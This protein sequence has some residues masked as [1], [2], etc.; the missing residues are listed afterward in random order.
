[1]KVY[2]S[3]FDIM[4][5]PWATEVDKYV[6]KDIWVRATCRRFKQTFDSYIRVLDKVLEDG[7]IY[8]L[9]NMLPVN[10]TFDNM[11]SLK[12]EMGFTKRFPYLSIHITHPVELA[13]TEDLISSFY[14]DGA[15][16][17]TEAKLEQYIGTDTWVKIDV[18]FLV[19]GNPYYCTCYVRFLSKDGDVYTYNRVRAQDVDDPEYQYTVYYKDDIED[20]ITEEY[21][22]SADAFGIS[23]NPNEMTTDEIVS[24]LDKPWLDAK[25]V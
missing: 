21:Q 25:E 11:P 23:D 20:L 12:C 19:H 14:L 9:V 2:A 1:M 18:G 8:Y 13:T 22:N 10:L 7:N 3:N 6:G 5:K 15:T 16:E 4:A 24:A 17:A